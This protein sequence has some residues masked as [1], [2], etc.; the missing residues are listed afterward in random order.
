[1]KTQQVHLRTARVQAPIGVQ[2]ETRTEGIFV[3]IEE[4]V[5]SIVLVITVI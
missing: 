4:D 2:V 1:M 3:G 5:F